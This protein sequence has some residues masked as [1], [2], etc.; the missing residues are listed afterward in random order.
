MN[1]DPMQKIIDALHAKEARRSRTRRNI[2]WI[3]GFVFYLICGSAAYAILWANGL[4]AATVPI[5][6]IYLLGYMAG[7][8]SRD[9]ER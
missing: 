9:I 6:L 3:V 1:A 8:V 7:R 2:R 4:E 5:V